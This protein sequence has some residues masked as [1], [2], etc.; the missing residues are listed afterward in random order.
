MWDRV[1]AL[2]NESAVL[3]YKVLYKHEGQSVT[4]GSGKG[5]NLHQPAPTQGQWL[6]RAGDPFLGG[7][8]VMG[9]L[10]RLLFPVI[11]ELE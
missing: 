11:Q 9:R 3:G 1:K 7:G 6:R 5:P 8:G 4:E 10:V 2:K